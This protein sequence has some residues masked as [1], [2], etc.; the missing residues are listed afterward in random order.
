MWPQSPGLFTNVIAA[1]VR[2]RNTSREKSLFEGCK[3][4]I[5][6]VYGFA[7]IKGAI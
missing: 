6:K 1:I 7:I 2:P 5:Y 3:V 4:V